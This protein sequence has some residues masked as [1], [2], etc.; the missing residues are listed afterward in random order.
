MYCTF[1]AITIG[2]ELALGTGDAVHRPCC[3]YN[4][5]N[6]IPEVED[7]QKNNETGK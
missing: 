4:S 1:E 2:K 6:H 3:I 7:E 5:S